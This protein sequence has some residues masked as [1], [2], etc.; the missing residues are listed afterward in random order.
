MDSADERRPL[1]WGIAGT[2]AVS[3]QIAHDLHLVESASLVAVA[4]RS[5]ERSTRFAVD[6]DIPNPFDDYTA[7][8]E[9]DIDI[10]YLCTPHVTHFELARRALLHGKHV[11]CEKPL[12]LDA[13]EVRELAE[14][15]R[16]EGL[17]LMEA[18]WMKFN[19]LMALVGDIVRSGEIGQVRAVQASF[20][21]PFPQDG[22]SRWQPGGSALL[23]QGIYPVTLSHMMLGAPERVHANGTVRADGNDLSEHFTLEYDGGRFAHGAS[24]MV[25]FLSSSAAI[26]G[27]QGWI[28]IDPGF[29]FS[30]SLTVHSYGPEGPRARHC[31]VDREGHGYTPMLRAANDAAMSGLLEHPT[32]T[33]EDTVSVFETLD[34]IRRDAFES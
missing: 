8:L 13:R 15:A 20:G 34:A 22:S 26:S 31:T 14:L 24:S 32:H 33:L 1:R 18:M 3:K 27:D 2:G 25:E 6:F 19:P 29:W 16:D 17:F 10:V 5:I 4:S 7:M 28:D 21:A 23:D 11:L 9:S 30:S 12:G